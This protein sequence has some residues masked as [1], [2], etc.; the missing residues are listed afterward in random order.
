MRKDPQTVGLTALHF[1]GFQKFS[2]NL[3][4]CPFTGFDRIFQIVEISQIVIFTLK[5]QSGPVFIPFA[6]IVNTPDTA[7]V[8]R[9]AGFHFDLGKL[10]PSCKARILP[11]LFSAKITRTGFAHADIGIGEGVGGF[12]GDGT[13]IADAFP[14]PDFSGTTGGI[15]VGAFQNSESS[16]ALS[17]QVPAF[18]AAAA[19]GGAPFQIVSQDDPLGAAVTLT[20]PP[21]LSCFCG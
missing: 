5:F 8:I 14:E 13:T 21:A 11:G 16:D 9:S 17:G 15:P 2:E 3:F 4:F 12:V 6:V 10:G 7:Y 18:F 19:D 1:P 20:E